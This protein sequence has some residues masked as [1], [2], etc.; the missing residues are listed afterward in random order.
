MRA[1]AC[2][3]KSED[4]VEGLLLSSHYVGCENKIQVIGLGGRYPHSM[5]HL[6]S[7]VLPSLIKVHN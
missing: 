7:P 3:S 5:S 6:A 2:V 4:N 1:K